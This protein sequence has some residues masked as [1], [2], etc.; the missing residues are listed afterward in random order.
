MVGLT[1]IDRYGLSYRIA[2]Q[3]LAGLGAAMARTL[4]HPG[5]LGWQLGATVI[6]DNVDLHFIH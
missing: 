1:F 4:P 5:E 2:N 6:L 3:V